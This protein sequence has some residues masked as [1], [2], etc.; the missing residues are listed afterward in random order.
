MRQKNEGG[1]VVDL[2]DVIVADEDLK[3]SQEA[4][5]KTGK[6]GMRRSAALA[7]ARTKKE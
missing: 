4:E 3:M 7:I 5:A 1:K 2:D 6:V